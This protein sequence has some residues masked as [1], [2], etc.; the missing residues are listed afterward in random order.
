VIATEKDIRIA[1]VQ[2][3]SIV[4]GPGLR[5]AIFFQGCPHLCEGCHNPETWGFEGGQSATAEELVGKLD[6]N[7]LLQGVTFSGGE[8]MVRAGALLPVAEAIAVRGLDLAVYTGYTFEEI[9]EDGDPDALALMVLASTLV[10]G[11]FV[12]AERSLSLPFR[13][14]KNQ[15]ILDSK[16]SLAAGVPVPTTDGR[17]AYD[18]C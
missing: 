11:R 3:D 9:L 4:D 10:D 14:S 5:M 17:W 6:A 15:R 16:A 7:P 12:L 13:G 2:N 8:P 18:S 1:G